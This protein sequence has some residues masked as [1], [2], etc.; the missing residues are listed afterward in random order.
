MKKIIAA[1]CALFAT[2]AA[3]ATI[4]YTNT[5]LVVTMK[6]GETAEFKFENEPMATF[7]GEEVT[8]VNTALDTQVVYTYKMSEIQDLTFRSE[9]VGVADVGANRPQFA[10]DSRYV[11]ADKLPAGT[12]LTVV[13]IDG[14]I[15][16]QA[17]AD[18]QGS[19]TLDIAGLPNGAYIVATPG[20]SFKFIK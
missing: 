5:T 4:P 19:V 18:T 2:L 8:F 13:G 14:K 6:S 7:E 1:A 11:Y 3:Q 12:L 9:G 16:A 10:V 17:Q 15:M 20:F